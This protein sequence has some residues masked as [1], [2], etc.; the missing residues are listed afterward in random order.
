MTLA[1][2]RQVAHQALDLEAT[3]AIVVLVVPDRDHP[4]QMTTATVRPEGLDW[5]NLAAALA[6]ATSC[7]QGQIPPP[8][9]PEPAAEEIAPAAEVVDVQA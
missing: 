5:G 2:F 8:A 9:A 1:Y 3:A 4:G 6:H 7:A